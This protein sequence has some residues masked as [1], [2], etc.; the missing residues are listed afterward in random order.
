VLTGDPVDNIKGLKGI[1]PAKAR[2]ILSGC[3]T[4][5]QLFSAAYNAYKRVYKDKADEEM[6]KNGQLVKIRQFPEQMW[7]FPNES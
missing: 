5:P 1:G 3:T 4:E 2:F 7:S 6:L